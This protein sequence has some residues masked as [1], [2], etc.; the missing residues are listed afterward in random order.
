[1][2]EFVKKHRKKIV[3]IGVVFLCYL[4]FYHHSKSYEFVITRNLITGEIK[5]DSHTGHHLTWPW[6][7]AVK[8]DTRPRKVCIPSA[9]RNMNCRLVQFDTSQWRALIK[10]EGF[11]YYW[12]YNRISFNWS[13]KT[14]RGVDNL[15]LGHA[16]GRTRGSFVKILQETGDE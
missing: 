12:W 6:V 5:P 15:L 3:C 10:Y 11:S 4:M 14:Y 7:Q 13:Q 16:Y 8:I 1:M 9:S 2:K